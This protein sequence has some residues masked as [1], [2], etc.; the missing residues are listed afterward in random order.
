MNLRQLLTSTTVL[1][2]TCL[3]AASASAE[4]VCSVTLI[5]A[6]STLGSEGYFIASF[7]TGADCTG[8]LVA[9]RHFCTT[10]ATSPNCA[11]S[12]NFRYNGAGL[13]SMH[14]SYLLAA[15]HNLS[16]QHI[17]VG[18]NGGGTT[19]GGYTAFSAR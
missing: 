4:Y 11:S 6:N 9:S 2:A 15:I 13:M 5:P 10:G 1:L 16:V 18:C 7:Y 19:C 17:T 14:Q 8:S 12:Q 3:G